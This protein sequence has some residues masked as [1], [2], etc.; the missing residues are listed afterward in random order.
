MCAQTSILLCGT[1][2]ITGK[3]GNRI[4][5][6]SSQCSEHWKEPQVFFGFFCAF[7]CTL[8]CAFFC[9]PQILALLF[10]VIFAQRNNQRKKY[11]FVLRFFVALCKYLRFILQQRNNQ[12][13]KYRFV[14]R[15]FCALQIFAVYFAE[16]QQL[17]PEIFFVAIFFPLCKYLRILNVFISFKKADS[18]YKL[19]PAESYGS[20]M[21]ICQHARKTKQNETISL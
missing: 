12:R 16:A 19:A 9:D 4:N 8:F 5:S 13:K 7:V 15:F 6:D 20:Y 17:A 2:V 10:A 11:R 3:I 21:L 14:L 1:T 18:G